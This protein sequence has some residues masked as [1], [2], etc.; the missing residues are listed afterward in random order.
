MAQF[1]YK[2][3]SPAGEVSEGELEARDEA[4]AL[5]RLQALGLIPIRIE[6]TE[7]TGANATGSL[8]SRKRI[9]VDAR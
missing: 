4:A 3:A 8:F 7:V 5:E 9:S 1:H 2:A 6:A